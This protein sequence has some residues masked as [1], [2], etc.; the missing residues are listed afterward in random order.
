MYDQVPLWGDGYKEELVRYLKDR[1]GQFFKAKFLASKTGFPVRGTQAELRKAVTELLEEGCPI[2]ANSSGF[3]WAAHPNMLKKYMQDL[4][5]R[6]LGLNRRID[7][8][9]MIWQ[10]WEGKE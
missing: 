5:Y 10:D 1:P 9:R 2:V 6:L 3:A 4:E 7:S 8:V